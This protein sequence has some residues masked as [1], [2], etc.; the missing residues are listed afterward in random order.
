MRLNALHFWA[1]CAA[2]EGAGELRLRF[3]IRPSRI[4]R[5]PP[6]DS[7]PAEILIGSGDLMSMIME[8]SS[9]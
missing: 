2:L 5:A 9:L 1:Y 8:P 6:S 7:S 3:C 4:R